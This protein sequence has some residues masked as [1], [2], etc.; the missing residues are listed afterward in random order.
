VTVNWC[1]RIIQDIGFLHKHSLLYR[2]PPVED[3]CSE[4]VIYHNERYVLYDNLSRPLASSA[5]AAKKHPSKAEERCPQAS[6]WRGCGGGWKGPGTGILDVLQDIKTP[7]SRD[8]SSIHWEHFTH[9]TGDR[10]GSGSKGPT[11][12]EES[13]QLAQVLLRLV[14]KNG[15]EVRLLLTWYSAP[16]N[17]CQAEFWSHRLLRL[18]SWDSKQNSGIRPCSWSYPSFVEVVRGL[19]SVCTGTGGTSDDLD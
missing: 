12:W 9:N 10:T 2:L 13:A 19:D 4:V 7:W 17:T 16:G 15:H 14:V 11:E 6:N 3:S 5:I 1:F 8:V 18:T